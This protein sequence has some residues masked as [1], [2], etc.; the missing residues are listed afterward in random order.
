MSAATENKSLALKILT[1]G[2][3]KGCFATFFKRISSVASKS[4]PFEMIICVGDF[5]GSLEDSQDA[6]R[7]I[8]SDLKSGKKKVPAPIYLLGPVENGQ[9]THFPDIEGC[10]LAEDIIYL[11]R[12]GVMTTSS[13]LKIA[14]ASHD[15]DFEAVK[16]LEIRTKCDETNFQG[17][18]ILL[19]NDWPQGRVYIFF[20]I[21]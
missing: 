15:I 14:Y 11:G 1:C 5:F 20:D 4:G 7:D 8:W 12:I 13:G 19:T 2:D 9:K 16:S 21:F 18:D 10:E 3:V 6:D 17:V